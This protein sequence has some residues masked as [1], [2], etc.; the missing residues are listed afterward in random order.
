[1]E[2]KT[3]SFNLDYKKSL[4]DWTL[5]SGVST[6]LQNNFANP[7]TGIRP[8]I[9][10][11]DKIDFGIYGILSHEF[12][13]TFSVDTGL[14]YD[15]S[16]T[17]ATKY[18]QKSRWE[19]RGY[20]EQFAHFIVADY[21]TQWLTKPSFTFHN[22]SASLGF[23]KVF[24][25]NWDWF[26]NVSFASRNPNP[27]EFF[28]DG[29]HHS[30]GVIELGDLGL[31]KEQAAKLSITVQKKYTNFSLDL[32]PYINS[33]KNYMYLKPV[34]FET[35]IRG[36]FPVWEYKQTNA[37]LIGIDLQT[38]WNITDQWQHLFS[39]AYV[40]GK[41]ISNKQPLIDMPP[42]NINNKISF[43][44]KEW[45]EVLLEL[46]SEIVCRQTRYPNNNFYTN[47]IKNDAFESVLIDISNPPPAY[48]L[49]HFY[50]EMKFS[51]FKNMQATLGFS[52][53]NLLDTHYRDY[54]NRQRFFADEV[55]RSFQV[56]LKFNY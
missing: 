42:L 11:Y 26:S 33:I 35:T 1:M 3:H 44:K 20:N 16:K 31:D 49:L 54:L 47:I 29:L 30:T 52:V 45:H 19:E 55:G 28:S 5:K 38:N 37:R 10:N 18:Y 53:Q 6:V 48:H 46:K 8:L 40:N 50:S 4:H 36:A 9:P 56:Q 34:G 27:S 17:D 43:S 7:K 23:H 2:L 15:F 41:D 51:I 24:E 22:I 13:D 12:T 39:F 25:N 32:N 14:R 21:A